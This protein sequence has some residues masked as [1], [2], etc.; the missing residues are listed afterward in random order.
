M[1]RCCASEQRCRDAEA[2][3]QMLMS[4]GTTPQLVVVQNVFEELKR[5]VPPK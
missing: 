5:L 2:V 1:L 4:A 3:L